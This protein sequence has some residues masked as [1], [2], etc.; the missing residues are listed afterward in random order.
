MKHW[1]G[2]EA[3][4]HLMNA[5]SASDAFADA[6]G[7]ARRTTRLYRVL[8]FAVH[9]DRA[10]LEGIT[11]SDAESAT[12]RLNAFYE[13]VKTAAAGPTAA[14]PQ[15]SAHLVGEHATYVLGARLSQT[16]L[17][18]TYATDQPGVFVDISRHERAYTDALLLAA[19]KMS[20]AGMSA[21][22]PE[23]L[24]NGVTQDRPWVAFWI[25]DGA[26]TLR[27]VL[28]AYPG[29]L[30]GRDWAWMFRRILMTLDIAGTHGGLDLDSILIHPEQHG[31]IIT[32]WGRANYDRKLADEVPHVLDNTA[33]ASICERM[34]AA[35][36]RRQVQFAAK[37]EGVAPGELLRQYDLLLHHL[38]GE[39]RYRPF[40][41]PA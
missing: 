31:V 36:E 27:Q 33:L 1:T 18:S 28:T 10:D 12:T 20:A 6:A 4:I 21:F 30:D 32:G 41:M 35:T 22:V 29:G 3:V 7:D 2:P 8:A 19:E 24:D 14:K 17:I 26:V 40:S 9:P 15:A 38:Y 25:L 39:R 5:A 11:A 16:T 34:L 23:I 37:A 13:Q